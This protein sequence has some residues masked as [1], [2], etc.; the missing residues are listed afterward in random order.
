MHI[1]DDEN[2]IKESLGE[3]D[4]Q[5]WKE[6]IEKNPSKYIH[7]DT[8]IVPWGNIDG[9]Q[10]VIGCPCNRLSLYENLFWNSQYII[11]DY[12]SLRAKKDLEKAEENNTLVTRLAKSVK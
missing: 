12:F 10:A 6:D 8:D 9:K 11:K 2:A 1:G 4:Y 7:H 3:K 5:N